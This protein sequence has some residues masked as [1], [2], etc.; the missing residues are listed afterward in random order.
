MALATLDGATNVVP[1]FI[2]ANGPVREARFIRN[3][4]GTPDG[5]VH[6]L[7]TISGRTDAVGC[8]LAQPNFAQALANNNVIFRIPTPTL[9]PRLGGDDA[10]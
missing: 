2:T 5:G 6:G 9:R 4:N 7:Y 1:S 8:T 10:G 3:P